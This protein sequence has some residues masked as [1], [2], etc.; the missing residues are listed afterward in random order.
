MA[1]VSLV[2]SL[3]LVVSVGNAE[4]RR[5]ATTKERA[6]IAARFDAPAKCARIWVSTVDRHWA[7]YAFD[8]TK[9]Q[10]ADCK[11]AAADGVA[12]LRLRNGTWRMV[13]A[14][15]SFHC[16]VPKTPAKIAKDLHVRCFSALR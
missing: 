12:I 10:D 14:G 1:M 15:S 13:T 9:Y 11:S 2:F 8:D 7:T 5:K 16:P 6:A 3:L 4:A